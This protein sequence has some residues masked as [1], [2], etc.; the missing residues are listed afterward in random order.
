MIKTMHITRKLAIEDKRKS[1]FLAQRDYSE[2]MKLALDSNFIQLDMV[3][4]QIKGF[5]VNTQMYFN[6]SNTF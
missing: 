3:S 4:F 5:F 1:I 2:Q 6:L